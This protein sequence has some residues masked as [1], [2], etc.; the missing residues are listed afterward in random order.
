MTLSKR[1]AGAFSEGRPNRACHSAT[2]VPFRVELPPTSNE[3]QYVEKM[4]LFVRNQFVHW[5]ERIE[6][7]AKLPK[8]EVHRLKDLRIDV[9]FDRN[10]IGSVRGDDVTLDEGNLLVGYAWSYATAKFERGLVNERQFLTWR[11]FFID[12]IMMG[13]PI[14]YVDGQGRYIDFIDAAG[15]I[16][17]ELRERFLAKLNPWIALTIM[18]EAAHVVLGHGDHWQ[19]KYPTLRSPEEQGWSHEHFTLSRQFELEADKKA[20]QLYMVGAGFDPG[21]ALESWA[22]WQLVRREAIRYRKLDVFPT[23]PEPEQRVP[24]AVEAYATIM[25][26]SGEDGRKLS[27]ALHSSVSA[28]R[29]RIRKKVPLREVP[30]LRGARPVAVSP[31]RER[32]ELRDMQL[33]VLADM[34]RSRQQ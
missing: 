31:N 21:P 5:V 19:R 34:P 8:E 20:L 25:G 16:D 12:S 10:S 7:R 32:F 18:H 17:V 11:D 29:D 23:H 26:T 14:V 33:R 15:G 28:L 2:A 6:Q 22:E 27:S 1:G 4:K 3:Q 24:D 9:R 30:R 13:D